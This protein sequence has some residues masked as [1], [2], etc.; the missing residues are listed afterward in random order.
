MQA[1]RWSSGIDNEFLTCAGVSGARWAVRTLARFVVARDPFRADLF[2]N[3]AGTAGRRY[4]ADNGDTQSKG[5][6]NHGRIELDARHRSA[7][8][9]AQSVLTTRGLEDLSMA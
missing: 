7:T 8:G 3:D 2:E 9:N 5:A 6:T 4:A 1:G